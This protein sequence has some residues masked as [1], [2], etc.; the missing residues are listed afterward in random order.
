MALQS[1]SLLSSVALDF[2]IQLVGWALASI[3]KTETFYD[4]TGSLTFLTLAL[5]SLLWGVAAAQPRSRLVTGLV[6]AWALRLGTFLFR[7]IRKDHGRDSRFDG[8]RDNPP[9][10]L[11]YWTI[12]GVWVALTLMPCLLLNG[13]ASQPPLGWSDALGATLMPRRCDARTRR[14]TVARAWP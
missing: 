8:V 11:L 4:L 12:Q 1:Q 13:T 10:F 3:L 6:C 14:F 9:K 5:R 2:G 7:R